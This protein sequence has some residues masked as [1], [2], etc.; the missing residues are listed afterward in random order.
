MNDTATNSTGTR[1]T[2]CCRPIVQHADS[3]AV[4]MLGYMNREALA[5][6]QRQRPRDVLEPQQAA[7]VDQG[8]DL[9]QLL[10]LRGIAADCDGDTL[11]IL[12]EPRGPGLPH[13]ARRPASARCAARRRRALSPSSATLESSSRSA[14]RIARRAATPRRLRRRGHRCASRRKS[15][16]KASKWRSPAP[17]RAMSEVVSEAADLVYHLMLLL[18]IKGLGL[19]AVVGELERRHAAGATA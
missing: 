16:R 9:G 1:A 19:A 10:E 8:R 13:S 14:S 12:A 11:L 4:L 18:E 5:A 17:R 7:S 2:A 6:T 15:A 3:G